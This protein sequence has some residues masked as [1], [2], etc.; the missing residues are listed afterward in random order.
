MDTKSKVV[1]IFVL[2]LMAISV[3]ALF[4]K[5]I[6]LQDFELLTVDEETDEVG[7]ETL[8]EQ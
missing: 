4:Y 3:S 7:T 8:E 2:V 1:F 6:I 5:S